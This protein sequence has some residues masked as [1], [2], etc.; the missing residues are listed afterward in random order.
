MSDDEAEVL[1]DSVKQIRL[2]LF[3][4]YLIILAQH[5]LFLVKVLPHTSLVNI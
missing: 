1:Y 4:L 3:E 5:Y 2:M